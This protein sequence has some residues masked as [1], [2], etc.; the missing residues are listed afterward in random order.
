M[1]LISKVNV[2]LNSG[3]ENVYSAVLKSGKTLDKSKCIELSFDNSRHGIYPAVS[4]LFTVEQFEELA[5]F[6]EDNK[7]IKRAR[8]NKKRVLVFNNKK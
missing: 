7:S 3:T 6:I 5:K 4:I 1:S 8:T 2:Q